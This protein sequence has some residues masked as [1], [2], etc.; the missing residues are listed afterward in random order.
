M[1][2]HAPWLPYGPF[3][4]NRLPSIRN[5]R[6]RTNVCASGWTMFL[7]SVLGSKSWHVVAGIVCTN[8]GDFLQLR[9]SLSL[10]RT[11]HLC[12]VFDSLFL[13]ARSN[14]LP[15]WVHSLLDFGQ[16]HF[17]NLSWTYHFPQVPYFTEADSSRWGGSCRSA[18]LWPARR[19]FSVVLWLSTLP[20]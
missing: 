18:P 11:S 14:H 5:R 6:A 13:L 16:A 10:G 12:P 3:G 20:K 7:G 4:G 8:P 19:N 2:C 9:L 1:P 17:P 15:V